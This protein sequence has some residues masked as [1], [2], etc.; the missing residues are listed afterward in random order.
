LIRNFH[1]SQSQPITNTQLNTL[2]VTSVQINYKPE[3]SVA[4]LNQTSSNNKNKTKNF[5]IFGEK[6]SSK[7]SK[8]G[9]KSK[10]QNN[11]PNKISEYF[12]NSPKQ[13]QSLIN[14]FASQIDFN[15]EVSSTYR[16][17]D[18]S[19][20]EPPSTNAFS[21]FLNKNGK[22]STSA[23]LK[24]VLS[25]S[26]FSSSPSLTG[27][28]KKKRTRNN[29]T[30][31]DSPKTNPNCDL[32]KFQLDKSSRSFKR[33][34]TT[35]N[36]LP[37]PQ[38]HSTNSEWICIN[39]ND[40]HQNFILIDD[41]DHSDAENS[42]SMLDFGEDETD[43]LEIKK[44]KRHAHSNFNK[45]IEFLRIEEDEIMKTE[46]FILEANLDE[47]NI[48]TE[49][50]DSDRIFLKPNSVCLN[51][52]DEYKPSE[53]GQD[54][55]CHNCG[56][57]LAVIEESFIEHLPKEIK[58]KLP[59]EIRSF[60]KNSRLKKNFILNTVKSKKI[61]NNSMTLRPLSTAHNKNFRFTQNSVIDKDGINCWQYLEC[62]NCSS[63]SGVV[64]KFSNLSS[65]DSFMLKL[66]NNPILFSF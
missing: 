28:N 53:I 15:P 39:D 3:T 10:D 2:E 62:I 33:Q 63:L 14:N 37:S 21:N 19:E 8:S 40:E 4:E 59:K 54:F 47:S 9:T 12:S 31:A 66:K 22:Y 56:T 43:F 32:S 49:N 57:C 16:P 35:T 45:S 50:S 51:I 60:I 30:S 64:L 27:S 55:K 7:K 41:N 65:D 29:E 26:N 52:K 61:N 46:N 17:L 23:Q 42:K 11:K 44:R 20:F 24:S 18:Q 13:Q 25:E 1:T 48:V 5:D 34:Q 58:K 6:M 38:H 36:N